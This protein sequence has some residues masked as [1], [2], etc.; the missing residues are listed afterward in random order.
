[1]NTRRH[2]LTGAAATTALLSWC[3][4]ALASEAPLTFAHRGMPGALQNTR[5][6]V[7]QALKRGYTGIEVDVVLSKDDRLVL[8]HDPWLH[9]EY[10]EGG[11]RDQLIRDMT[12]DA[13]RER[14]VSGQ[15]AMELVELLE[16]LPPTVTLYLD[17][18]IEKPMTGLT[19]R[20]RAYARAIFGQWTGQVPLVIEAPSGRIAERYRDER[21]EGYRTMLSWPR[22][23]ATTKG[24]LRT[25]GTKLGEAVCRQDPLAAARRAGVDGY[26][27][28][29]IVVGSQ[30]LVNAREAGMDV[31]VFGLTEDEAEPLREQGAHVIVDVEG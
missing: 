21:A 26:T 29:K 28:H 14:K 18:K 27:A 3:S 13:I 1:M 9:P 20:G 31:V 5:K 11:G 22:Y 30:D 24:T 10:V 17:V 6:G 2:F 15:E 12:W 23:T 7:R 8:S 16:M 19:R 4:P 25:I